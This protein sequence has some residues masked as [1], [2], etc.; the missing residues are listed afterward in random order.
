MA[1]LISELKKRIDETR[2]AISITNSNLSTV[3]KLCSTKLSIYNSTVKSTLTH[4]AETWPI[5]WKHR[6]KL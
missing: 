5:K 1:H 2:R 6:Y 3:K 4:A